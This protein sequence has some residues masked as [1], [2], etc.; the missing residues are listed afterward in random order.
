MDWIK[1]CFCCPPRHHESPHQS[2][3]RLRLDEAHRAYQAL[4][5]VLD[6][7]E[8]ERQL[9]KLR[10]AQKLTGELH[11]DLIGHRHT[12]DRSASGSALSSSESSRTVR[13]LVPAGSSRSL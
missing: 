13:P 12:A 7:V 4:N 2:A 9:R 8:D 11:Y 3:L 6:L 5:A 10:Q 1:R